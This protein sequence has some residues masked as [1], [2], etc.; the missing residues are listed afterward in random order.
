MVTLRDILELID[1]DHGVEIGYEKNKYISG[2]EYNRVKD[3]LDRP[4]KSIRESM[5]NIVIELEH[6]Q[7]TQNKWQSLIDWC[8]K[9]RNDAENRINANLY[10]LEGFECTHADGEYG[11]FCEVIKKIKEIAKGE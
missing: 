11:A 1:P 9:A 3:Y 7:Q 4:V 10:N 2:T 6:I 8:V 5:D